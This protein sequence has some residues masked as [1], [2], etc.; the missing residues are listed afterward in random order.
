[1]RLCHGTAVPGGNGNTKGISTAF[2][3]WLHASNDTQF[4]QKVPEGRVKLLGR[5]NIV[6]DDLVGH[7]S[8]HV[9]VQFTFASE[10]KRQ[11][12]GLKFLLSRSES[13]HIVLV[14]LLFLL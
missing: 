10:G 5:V 13:S 12:H 3:S 7:A 1:V 2:L 8:W 9:G 14:L 11:Q 4:E 6:A